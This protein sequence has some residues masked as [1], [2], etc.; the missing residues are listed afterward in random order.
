LALFSQSGIIAVLSFP[1]AQKM[2]LTSTVM[3]ADWSQQLLFAFVASYESREA[4]GIS[5]GSGTEH[6]GMQFILAY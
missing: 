4:L 1:I 5:E 2:A 3:I 6:S